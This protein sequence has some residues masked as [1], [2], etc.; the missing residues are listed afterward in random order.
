MRRSLWIV[1][2]LAS[3]LPVAVAQMGGAAVVALNGDDAG[4][5][6]GQPLVAVEKTSSI[7]PIADGNKITKNTEERKWRDSQGRF[8]KE[9]TQVPQGQEA[10]YHTATIIDPVNN[11]VTTLNLDRKIATVMHLPEQGPFKLHPY[12]DLDDKPLA[13]MPGVQVK[14]EK[15]NGKTI[16]GVYAVG[17][18]V[19][20]TRP[21]GTVGNDKTIVS[22]SER[23]V[24]PD[25]KILLASSMEDPRQQLTRQVTQLDRS[26][27]DPTLFQIPSDFTVKEIPVRQAQR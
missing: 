5:L 12:V 22:V 20:R 1:G 3:T 14:V 16:A 27:P 23:W 21:P 6:T 11:T 19:T 9:V 7:T 15:L 25:L 26:E 24:S 13:A 17:R 18:R 4:I 2:V 8:R 10:I